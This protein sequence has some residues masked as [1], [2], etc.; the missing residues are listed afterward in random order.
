MNEEPGPRGFASSVYRAARA[1]LACMALAAIF[2]AGV[3]C[4]WRA[5][6]FVM[7]TA[8]PFLPQWLTIPK[9][10]SFLIAWLLGNIA[11]V[12]ILWRK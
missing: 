1:L 8:L 3:W 11:L 9:F 4:I 2:F 6:A 5:Y 7:P 12:V 10:G